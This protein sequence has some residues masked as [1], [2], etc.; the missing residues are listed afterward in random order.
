MAWWLPIAV[1]GWPLELVVSAGPAH[2]A[3]CPKKKQ[4]TWSR[5]LVALLFF[6]QPIVRGWARY[7]WAWSERAQ[8]HYPARG[9]ATPGDSRIAATVSYWSSGGLDRYAF[10]SRIIARLQAENW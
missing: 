2:K 3:D 9:A 5:P 6:L 7:K 4:R 10:L 8:P 1:A